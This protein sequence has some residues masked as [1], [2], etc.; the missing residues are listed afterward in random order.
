VIARYPRRR[1]S[2]PLRL[3]LE[4]ERAPALAR[5]EAEE[6][7]LAL[8]RAAK[9]PDPDVNAR[10]G[11]Y[12]VDFLWRRHN[13]VVEIDGFAFHSSRS[14]FE[15]DR[16]RDADLIAAGFRVIRVTWHQVTR[17]PEATAALIS[18]ALGPRP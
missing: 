6:R 17:R 7:L 12:E 14:A 9:L 18:R 11:P 16:A 1:G 3:L 10:L 5:S 2:R 15:R 8:I 13:L 4:L